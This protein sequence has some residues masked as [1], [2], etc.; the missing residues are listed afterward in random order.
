MLRLT[1]ML[2]VLAGF[3]LFTMNIMLDGSSTPDRYAHW[4]Q[5][6]LQPPAERSL[7]SETVEQEVETKQSAVKKD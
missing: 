6:K 1:L 5:K 3:A 4:S 2:S 7:L